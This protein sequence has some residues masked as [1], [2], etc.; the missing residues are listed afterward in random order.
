MASPFFSPATVLHEALTEQGFTYVSSVSF[1]PDGAFVLRRA[2]G[3]TV[4]TD[5]PAFVFGLGVDLRPTQ[6]RPLS[7]V[8]AD[9]GSL[10]AE[11]QDSAARLAIAKAIISDPKSFKTLVG[12]DIATRELVVPS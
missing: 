12:V 7:A 8:L 5:D 1:N 6:P 3:S 10:S 2:D 4:P 11:S 9:V